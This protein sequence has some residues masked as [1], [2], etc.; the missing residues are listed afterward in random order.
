VV[1]GPLQH[2]RRRTVVRGECITTM[3]V[4]ARLGAVPGWQ[5]G[6]VGGGG[7]KVSSVFR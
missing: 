5:S 6:H 7:N 3:G 1:P 2:G 4:E